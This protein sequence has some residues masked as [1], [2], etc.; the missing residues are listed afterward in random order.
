MP[1]KTKTD[2]DDNSEMGLRD[3]MR[4]KLK[5]DTAEAGKRDISVMTRLSSSMVEVLDN[6]VKLGIFKSRSDAVAA[7]VEKALIPQMKSFEKLKGHVEQLD[8][9]QEAAMDIAIKALDGQ[10]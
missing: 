6:L 5:A 8:E 1:P 9:I 10:D 3:E 7:I 4:K 2:E